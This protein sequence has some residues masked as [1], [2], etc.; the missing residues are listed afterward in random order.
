MHSVVLSH[1]V[2]V[3]GDTEGIEI[4]LSALV[5]S[6]NAHIALLTPVFPP[7]IFDEPKLLAVSLL[8]PTDDLNNLLAIEAESILSSMIDTLLVSQEISVHDHLSDYWSILQNLLLN[9]NVILGEAVINDF[10]EDAITSA[11]I[12][13]KV[14]LDIALALSGSVRVAS[15]RDKTLALA[16]VESASGIA[17]L[18]SVVTLVTA[19][20][21]LS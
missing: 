7:R 15:L 1:C 3:G 20:D 5:R 14:I 9:A 17:S 19:D 10:V 8:I 21:F 6:E 16:P 4:E 13:F 2:W 18:T 12:R 11:L